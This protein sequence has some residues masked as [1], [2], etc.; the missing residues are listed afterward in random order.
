[1]T[2]AM[3]INCTLCTIKQTGY[4]DYSITPPEGYVIHR[5]LCNCR[6]ITVISPTDL[7]CPC[8]AKEDTY[9]PGIVIEKEEK[10]A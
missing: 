5:D 6:N 9:V 3:I 7:R 1:M 4:G 8:Q 2:D 10:E